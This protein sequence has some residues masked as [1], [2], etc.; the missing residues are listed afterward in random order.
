MSFDLK[1]ISSLCLALAAMLIVGVSPLGAQEKTCTTE[2]IDLVTI[3]ARGE[4]MASCCWKNTLINHSS[5]K[6][7]QHSAEVRRLAEQCYTTEEILDEFV[8]VHGESILA[9][10]R[11]KG[12]GLWFYLGPALLLLLTG[13]WLAVKIVPGLTR[14]GQPLDMPVAA[15][16]AAEAASSE[17]DGAFESE[18]RDGS[19]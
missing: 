19:V 14:P 2:Q 8:S 16:Q 6:A 7:D 4:L 9:R 17:L 12:V 1:Y 3:E 15:G 5:P 11:T 18:L 10:P 13:V